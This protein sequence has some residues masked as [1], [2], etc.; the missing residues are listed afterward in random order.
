VPLLGG[1]LEVAVTDQGRRRQVGA[2]R[3]RHLGLCPVDL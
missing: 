1:S 3:H 2:L